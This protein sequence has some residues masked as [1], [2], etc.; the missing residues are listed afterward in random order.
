MVC[1]SPGLVGTSDL[2]C[3]LSYEAR[4]LGVWG[5]CLVCSV[6]AAVGWQL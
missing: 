6:P 4:C 1:T 5:E 2:S 3:L